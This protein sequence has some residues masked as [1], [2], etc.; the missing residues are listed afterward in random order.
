MQFFKI[1]MCS[2]QENP[3]W[4]RAY[5]SESRRLI[6]MSFLETIIIHVGCILTK[7]APY[8]HTVNY[9]PFPVLKLIS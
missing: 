3:H 5:I 2:S 7:M 6:G 1:N 9:L 8:V 4:K